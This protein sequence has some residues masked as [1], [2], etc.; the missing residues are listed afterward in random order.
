[1]APHLAPP[2]RAWGEGEA[3]RGGGR[4]YEGTEGW[5]RAMMVV[6]DEYISVAK[7]SQ[8]IQVYLCETFLVVK[9]V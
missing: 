5:N 1:M 2:R 7:K 8:M 9:D 4:G 6:G 3:G